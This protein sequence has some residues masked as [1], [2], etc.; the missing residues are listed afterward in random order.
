MKTLASTKHGPII[1][2]LALR[3]RLRRTFKRKRFA[4]APG[5]VRRLVLVRMAQFPAQH[6]ADVAR[7]AHLALG[8]LH[9]RPRRSVLVERHGHVFHAL[10]ITLTS[11]NYRAAP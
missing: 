11:C 8:R 1:E 5:P 10:D 3:I 9:A 7:Q 6:L 4:L 2:L